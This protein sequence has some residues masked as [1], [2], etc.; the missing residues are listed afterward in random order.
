MSGCHNIQPCVF[1]YA[2]LEAGS[3]SFTTSGPGS[4]VPSFPLTL[5]AI[6]GGV[7]G[8]L[9]LLICMAACISCFCCCTR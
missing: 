2:V 3:A 1:V 9:V 8:V 6:V 5:I 7:A 4:E